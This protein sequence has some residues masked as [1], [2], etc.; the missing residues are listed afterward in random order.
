MTSFSRRFRSPLRELG[1]YN[2]LQ[3]LATEFAEMADSDTAIKVLALRA[4]D[5]NS[6]SLSTFR[7]HCIP[8]K[9]YKI[10]SLESECRLSLRSRTAASAEAE[11]TVRKAKA[12]RTA[13]VLLPLPATSEASP[14]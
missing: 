5:T 3:R 7:G 13:L 11:T 1:G 2:L 4:M 14:T 8:A 9:I 10:H 6:P 12:T